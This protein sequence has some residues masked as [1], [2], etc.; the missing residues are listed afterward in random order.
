MIEI[1]KKLKL[2][3]T[4]EE[5]QALFNEKFEFAHNSDS[6]NGSD[7]YW[8]FE[9]FKASDYNREDYFSAHDDQDG[10][11]NRKIGA[12]LY[13]EWKNNELYMYSISY[14]NLEDNKVHLYILN[15]DATISDIPI[16]D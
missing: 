5:V 10:L 13:I 1:K 9:Y 4:K 16:S 12:Y 11:I 3:L 15:N 7:S 2:G 8:K 14:V 6:E